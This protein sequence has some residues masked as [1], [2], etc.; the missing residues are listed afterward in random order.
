[1]WRSRT[2]SHLRRNPHK[3]S[4]NMG[5]ATG[6]GRGRLRVQVIS[7]VSPQRFPHSALIS[8]NNVSQTFQLLRKRWGLKG[9]ERGGPGENSSPSLLLFHTINLSFLAIVLW[10]KKYRSDYVDLIVSENLWNS[11]EM[12]NGSFRA[13]PF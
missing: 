9:R 11:G 7:A 5:T 3:L 12:Q 4:G 2:Q 6:R 8:S 13:V 1:M 10:K